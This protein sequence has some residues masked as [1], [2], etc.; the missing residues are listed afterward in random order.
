MLE[1]IFTIEELE[2]IMIHLLNDKSFGLND[3]TTKI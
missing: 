2:N 1:V 3:I